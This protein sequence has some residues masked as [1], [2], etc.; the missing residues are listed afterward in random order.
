[1]V[2]IVYFLGSW[3]SRSLR[4]LAEETDRI[5]K[6]EPSTAPP[7]HSII[8][9]IDELGHSVATM[10]TTTEAFSR[11]VPRRLVERLIETGTP[12][13]LGG[14]RREVTLLFSDVV[15]FTAITE[16]ADPARAH[17]IYF[18]LLRGDVAGNHEPFRNRR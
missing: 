3:L 6:F 14:T 2:P 9:E 16:K 12:L 4:A 17:A 1:M 15:S 11:F 18:P 13:Q 7:V 8:R 10:R 5:Q